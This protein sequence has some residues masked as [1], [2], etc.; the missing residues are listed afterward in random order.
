MDNLQQTKEEESPKHKPQKK[1]ADP[2]IGRKV[3]TWM[4]V[5]D[6]EVQVKGTVIGVSSKKSGKKKGKYFEI[7]YDDTKLSVEIPNEKV[8]VS[9]IKSMLI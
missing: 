5:D 6:G 9:D 1:A 8:H 4:D 7:Q 3:Q 2:L